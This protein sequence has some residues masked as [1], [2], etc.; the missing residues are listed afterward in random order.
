MLRSMNSLIIAAVLGASL[1]VQAETT[2]TKVQ[3]I[4]EMSDVFSVSLLDTFLNAYCDNTTIEAGVFVNEVSPECI[5]RINELRDGLIESDETH[6][7]A[8]LVDEYMKSNSI[9]VL[10]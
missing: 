4:Q 1:N 2:S 9:P 10:E 3:L 5:V 6:Q 7:S 8:Q